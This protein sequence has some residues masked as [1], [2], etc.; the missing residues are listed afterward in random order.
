[1]PSL[2]RGSTAFVFPSIFEGFGIPV[3]EAL[4]QD[5]PVLISAN[6]SIT[7]FGEFCAPVFDN[8]DAALWAK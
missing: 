3:I 1:L 2:Y 7:Q 4:S 6:T 8:F 5:T